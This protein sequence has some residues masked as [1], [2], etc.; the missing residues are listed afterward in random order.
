M[1]ILH[2]EASTGWGGQEMRTLREVIA[3]R[4]HGFEV[5]LALAKGGVLATK[6]KEAGFQVYEMSLAIKKGLR[7]IPKLISMIR[8]H[9][10]VIV[11][12]HS[13]TD[14]WLGGIAA[15]LTG[16]KVI[17]TRHISAPIKPGWNSYLLYN[18]LA[19]RVI[20]TCESVAH[21]IRKQAH[22]PENRCLSIPTGI[23]PQSMPLEGSENFKSLYGLREDHF[24]I[25]TACIV[26]SWKGISDLLL[27]ANQLKK[28]MDFRW[29]I[30]GDGPY[31]QTCKEQMKSLGL[32]RQVIF[33]GFIENPFPAVQAM[34]VFTLVS[35]ANEGVSQASLQAA[36]LKKPMI[37]T[38]VGG[39]GEICVNGTTGYIVPPSSPQDL[40]EAVL[41]LYFDKEERRLFGQKA[42]QLVLEKFTFSKTMEKI[43]EVA[44]SVR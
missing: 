43:I 36:Y 19:D 41:K 34:D 33:T 14:A 15:R 24:I 1:N 35:T 38:A 4:K 12:T 17:R 27:A 25:G 3:M 21:I 18:V 10:I 44:E 39:L 13:S 20:T 28:Q 42:H 2:I 29:L 8:K 32:E 26:R 6:A 16:R 7:T 22:L 30:V 5:V 23:D 9:R 11:N 31:L 37:T 40:Q